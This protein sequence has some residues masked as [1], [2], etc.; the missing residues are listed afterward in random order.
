MAAVAEAAGHPVALAEARK[1]VDIA[2]FGLGVVIQAGRHFAVQSNATC[3]GT[4]NL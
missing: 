4:S 3:R 2:S 1:A